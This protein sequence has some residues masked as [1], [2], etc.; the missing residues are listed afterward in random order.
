MQAVLRV[1]KHPHIDG[2]DAKIHTIWIWMDVDDRAT[3]SCQLLLLS[4]R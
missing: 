1:V 4:A 2:M 3:A